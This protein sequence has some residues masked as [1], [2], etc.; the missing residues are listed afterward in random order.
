[1]KIKINSSWKNIKSMVSFGIPQE[2]AIALAAS[3]IVE[4]T[5]GKIY[6]QLVTVKSQTVGNYNSNGTWA[7][8]SVLKQFTTIEL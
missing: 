8:N 6:P 5:Q 4:A 7:L 2:E 3:T 1:M